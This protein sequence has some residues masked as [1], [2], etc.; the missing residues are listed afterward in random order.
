MNAIY[1][2]KGDHPCNTYMSNETY[3]K[4]KDPYKSNNI[5]PTLWKGFNGAIPMINP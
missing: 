2:G 3:T 4:K 5:K 1:I